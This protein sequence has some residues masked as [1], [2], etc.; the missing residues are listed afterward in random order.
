MR[1]RQGR[2]TTI[3]RPGA[4]ATLVTD[5]NDRGDIVG[6]SSAVGA[7]ELLS[8]ADG[9]S[10]L[11][12]RGVY[13]DIELPGASRTIVNAINNRGE[14]AGAYVDAAGA[15][16]G[17]VRARKG[18]YVSIDHPDAAGP[19]TTLYSIN[20]RGQTTGAYRRT[21]VQPDPARQRLSTPGAATGGLL[22]DL[23]L[24]G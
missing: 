8:G 9:N 22:N 5:L 17:F 11:L 6:D 16:H 1:D 24:I 3:A 10:F 13:R 23:T 7:D 4:A 2:F 19:G 18:R 12:D 15:T 20:D 21:L 14:M